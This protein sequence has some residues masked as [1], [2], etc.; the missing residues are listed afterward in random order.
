MF[1]LNLSRCTDTE[2]RRGGKRR[3]K[4]KVEFNFFQ[5][6]FLFHFIQRLFMLL[7]MSKKPLTT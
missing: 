1:S 6:G 4:A 5:K 3:E 7:A 2:G